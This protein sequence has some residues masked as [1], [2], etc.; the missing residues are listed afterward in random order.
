MKLTCFLTPGKIITNAKNS[1][2]NR[3]DTATMD[4]SYV[5]E[6]RLEIV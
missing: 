3:I 1:V 4:T 5:T 6:V 2:E